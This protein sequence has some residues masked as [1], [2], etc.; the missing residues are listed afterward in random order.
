[1]SAERKVFFL[2]A[3]TCTGSELSASTL[4]N[5]ARLVRKGAVVHVKAT[6][7]RAAELA[8]GTTVNPAAAQSLWACAQAEGI[9]VG[10]GMGAHELCLLKN[11]PSLEQVETTLTQIFES[12]ERGDLIVIALADAV[13]FYG[14]PF[15][16]GQALNTV[17]PLASIVPTL[18]Y[19]ADLPVPAHCDAAIIYAALKNR[20]YK[21]AEINKFKTTIENMEAALERNTR[22]PWGKHDCA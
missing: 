8:T 20:N 16:K 14:T 4:E 18:A 7:D 5:I 15:A 11:L 13:A 21:L 9:Q 17:Y 10:E 19:V 12:N 2:F 1:M 22:Q 3:D 6:A